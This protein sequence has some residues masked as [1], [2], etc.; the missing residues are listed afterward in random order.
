MTTYVDSS[1]L[2]K[3]YVK[4]PDSEYATSLVDA[5]SRNKLAHGCRSSSFVIKVAEG[6]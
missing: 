1:A 4:E 3:R 6:E 5:D 2:L